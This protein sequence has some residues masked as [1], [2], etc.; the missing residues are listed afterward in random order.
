MSE[1][2]L[3]FSWH[4]RFSYSARSFYIELAQKCGDDR[5]NTLLH[6][7]DNY[8]FHEAITNKFH[9]LPHIIGSTSLYDN[10]KAI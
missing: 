9:D 2:L 3:L 6:Q 10:R 7:I 5:R 4:H 8:R 1:F